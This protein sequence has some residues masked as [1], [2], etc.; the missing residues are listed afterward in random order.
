MSR[1]I[2][3]LLVNLKMLILKPFLNQIEI[4]K[5][6]F[7]SLKLHFFGPP[8]PYFNVVHWA[9]QPQAPNQH[10][11]GGAGESE[12]FEAF[13]ILW[14]W[15]SEFELLTHHT[16]MAVKRLL[17][18]WEGS[19]LIYTWPNSVASLFYDMKYLT[20]IWPHLTSAKKQKNWKW[21]FLTFKG[22]V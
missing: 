1:Y 13:Q 10:W 11:K 17:R 9:N 20:P 15:L 14:P 21:P 7:K 18:P 5:I 19:N 4:L 12:F 6:K 3:F 2:F 16:L 8:S 22:Q